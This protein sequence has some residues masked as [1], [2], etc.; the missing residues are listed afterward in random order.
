MGVGVMYLEINEYSGRLEGFSYRF[1]LVVGCLPQERFKSNREKTPA[2]SML[3]K[4]V[5]G[6][7]CKGA[8]QNELHTK[9]CGSF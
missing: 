5:S 7:K 8:F 6:I 4:A 3:H 1:L 2:V 9:S